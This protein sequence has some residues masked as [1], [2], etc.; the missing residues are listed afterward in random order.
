MTNLV[1]TELREQIGI[2]TLNNAAQRNALSVDMRL[3]IAAAL[4]ELNSNSEC[5][6]VI[7]AGAGGN[8]CAGGDL[9]S[10]LS[11]AEEP[12][13]IRTPRLLSMLHEIIRLIAEGSKPVIAAVDGHATGAGLSLAAACDYIVA[14]PT[15][16]FCASYGR[17]GLVPDAGLLWSLPRRIGT[18][19]A[20]NM[21]LT[22]AGIDLETAL[23]IGLADMVATE[24]ETLSTAF[25]IAHN[26][27]RVAPLAAAHIKEVLAA[28]SLSLDEAFEAEL[29]IQPQLTGSA[30]YMEARAAFAEKRQPRFIG[31]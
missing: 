26:Y 29:R 22:A 1:L 15:A 18:I 19:R 12:P 8:F 23:R 4:R 21:M 11:N 14:G 6:A 7:L 17:V 24:G 2:V 3:A 30:D 10:R 25:E 5:R 31:Q 27:L 13:E 9:K 16:K 28:D 20:R